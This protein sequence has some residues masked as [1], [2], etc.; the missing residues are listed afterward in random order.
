M[1]GLGFGIGIGGILNG[2]WEMA[3]GKYWYRTVS[4]WYT[5]YY[6]TEYTRVGE[7]TSG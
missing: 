1:K 2:G 7:E 6:T 4:A 5:C 3:V